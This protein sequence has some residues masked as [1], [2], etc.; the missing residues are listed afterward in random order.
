M[1]DRRYTRRHDLERHVHNVHGEQSDESS[2]DEESVMSDGEIEEDLEVTEASSSETEV[3]SESDSS[4]L[5]DNATYREWADQAKEASKDLWN[6]KYQKYIE[7]G[8]D[9]QRAKDKADMK[10]LFVV[11]RHFFDTY[12]DFLACNVHLR[13]NE[14]HQQIMDE[15]DE[16]LDKGMAIPK[17]L[18]RVMPKHHVKFDA[19]FQHEDSDDDETDDE[20]DEEMLT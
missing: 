4:D 13:D 20:E 3:D 9:D 17:A 12:E 2:N 14:T 18:K 6:E 7:E 8:M 5:E 15:L 11:K 16:K 10:T 19:L 1:C